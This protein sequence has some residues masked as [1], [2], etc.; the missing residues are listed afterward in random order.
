M[1]TTPALEG[2]RV[3]ELTHAIAGPHTG[4][5]LADHG[6]DVIKV[7]PPGGE[8][9]RGAMPLADEDSIYFAAQNRGKRSVVLNLKEPDDLAAL[10]RLV[11]D[12]DVVVTNYSV[13]VPE[14]LGWGFEALKAVN[15]SIIMV[16]ITGFGSTSPDRAMLAFDGIIQGM[17]GIPQMT[18]MPDGDPMF[19][20]TFVADHITAYRATMS[21]MMA[22]R[23]REASPE[24][25]FVDVNMLTS[26]MGLLAHDI[27]ESLDGRPYMR[28]GNRVPVSIANTY[29]AR[30]GFV[31]LAPVGPVK[32]ERFCRA[33]G[34]DDWAEQLPYDE[35]VLTGR[36]EVDE[37][38]AQWCR[39][40]ACDDILAL[41]REL[42]V[43]SGPVRE[44]DEAVR[45]LDARGDESV[46]RVTSPAGR[47]VAAPGPMTSVGLA[48][49]PRRLRVP[50][51]GEHDEEVL[52][53][54]RA[55]LRDRRP[56]A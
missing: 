50:A 46:V 7:E 12:S 56:P 51:I 26:Y 39:D 48:D 34:R 3:L 4:Q 20:G 35:A 32:W 30:D 37:Y 1:A 40:R 29:A 14:R 31:H 2:I 5:I 45:H 53:P 17:S 8:L 55:A 9:A 18:G 52:G 6:A 27:H 13:E 44:L 11:E 28:E 23:V 42:A 54:I 24:A 16:H 33:V 25:Q 43:P 15:P 22:L 10:L 49:G 19:I 38:L 21:V 47:T 36:D 41:M